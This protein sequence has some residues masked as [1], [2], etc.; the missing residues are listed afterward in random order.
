MKMDLSPA[1]APEPRRRSGGRPSQAEALKRDARLVEIAAAMFMERGFDATTIDAVA[2]AASVGKAT[3][4]ARYRDKAE[5]FAAVLRRQIDRWFTDDEL[6]PPPGD[7]LERVLLDIGRRML[8]ITLTPE[9]V[10]IRRIITAQAAR[11]PDLARLVYEEGTLRRIKALAELLRFYEAQGEIA[12]DDAETTAEL[13]TSLVIGHQTRIASLGV[14]L[15]PGQLD[16]R[17]RAA[18]RLFL[19]GVR[20]RAAGG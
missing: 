4:Y 7:P 15:E 11:F 20:P 14:P 18:V 3:V 9:A 13:F 5:L 10:A 16:R 8:A 17:L 6:I 19:D 12:L 1:G 2:E